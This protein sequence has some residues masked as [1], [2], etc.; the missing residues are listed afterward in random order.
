[1]P[2]FSSGTRAA[3]TIELPTQTE[4]ACAAILA[5]A[6]SYDSRAHHDAA[7][8]HDCPTCHALI[9]HR[10]MIDRVFV[11]TCAARSAL[12]PA[13]AAVDV[14][15]EDAEYD[16]LT[17]AQC[18]RYEQARFAEHQPHS[19]AM[20]AALL[21]DADAELAFAISDIRSEAPDF[22]DVEHYAAC[23]VLAMI[24]HA[25]TAAAFARAHIE[26][27]RPTVNA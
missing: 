11:P 17:A 6:G 3:K 8:K 4:R 2:D 25:P 9:N 24:T 15:T 20:I 7:L 16:D 10:C 1:M 5:D 27:G 23:A 12:V 19:V 22:D 18:T 13:P 14:S 21:P 26:A